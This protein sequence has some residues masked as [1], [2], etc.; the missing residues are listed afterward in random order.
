[1]NIKRLLNTPSGRNMISIILGL[2]LASLFQKV[3][4]DKDCLIFTGPIIEQVDGKIFKHQDN[5]YKYDIETAT[6]DASKRIIETSKDIARAPAPASM[7]EN[8]SNIRSY[9][10]SPAIIPPTK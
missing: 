9:W 4:K 6:C 10:S 3:C 8:I 7:L 2:G 5:C 1:M